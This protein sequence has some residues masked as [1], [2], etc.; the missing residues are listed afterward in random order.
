MDQTTHLEQIT[1]SSLLRYRALKTLTAK[2]TIYEWCFLFWVP[3]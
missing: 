1:N 2:N 3:L